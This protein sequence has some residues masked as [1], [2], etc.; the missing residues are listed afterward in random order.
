MDEF[1]YNVA[2]S[3]DLANCSS[4]IRIILYMFMFAFIITTTCSIIGYFKKIR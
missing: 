4:D 2:S 3:G 1:L